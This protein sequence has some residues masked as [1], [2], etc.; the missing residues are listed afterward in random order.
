MRAERIGAFTQDMLLLCEND[1]DNIGAA[2][3]KCAAD[4]VVIDS[5]Q[6]MIVDNVGTAPGTV[7]QV[8]EVT[9]RLM[10]LA[11]QHNVAIFIVG[12]V[13]KEVQ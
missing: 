5:I 13:T 9:S 1:M 3:Q 6:T 12:H 8:R 4:V 10:Q 7:T 11:K 2:V